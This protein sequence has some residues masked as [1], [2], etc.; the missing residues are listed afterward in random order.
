[1]IAQ[2]KAV[3]T[4]TAQLTIRLS[5][6]RKFSFPCPPLDEHREVSRRVEIAFGWINRLAFETRGA[7]KLIDHLDQAVLDEAFRG[8]LVPQDPNDE[9]ASVLLKRIRAERQGRLQHHE[10]LPRHQKPRKILQQKR[11]QTKRPLRSYI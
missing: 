4:G 1:V 3:A 2:A 11:W 8:E 10:E 7:H 6:L 9:P 5:G